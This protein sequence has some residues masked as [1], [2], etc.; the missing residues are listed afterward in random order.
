M[1]SFGRPK[2]NSGSYDG[3]DVGYMRE[4]RQRYKTV[5]TKDERK[6]RKK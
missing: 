3:V 1:P 2:G 5:T 4:I 6:R